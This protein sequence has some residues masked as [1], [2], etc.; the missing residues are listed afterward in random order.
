MKIIYERKKHQNK[1]KINNNKDKNEQRGDCKII[2]TERR[3]NDLA[4]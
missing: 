4:F 2:V 3:L 1:K